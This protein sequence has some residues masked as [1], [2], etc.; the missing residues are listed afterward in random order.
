MPKKFEPNFKTADEDL[1]KEEVN[2]LNSNGFVGDL[3][4]DLKEPEKPDIQWA[5]E[6]IAKSYGIYMEFDRAATGREKDWYYM[7][8]VTIPGGGPLDSKAWNIRDSISNKYT[9]GPRSKPS[10][11]LTT[12]QNI[13][14]HWI[15]K[16]DMIPLVQEIASTGYSTLNGCGDNTRNV[17]ACPLSRYSN[18]FNANTWAFKAA[19]YFQLDDEP[20]IKI[21]AVDP[22]YLREEGKEPPKRFNY[23]NKLL[24][25]KFKIAFGAISRDQESGKFIQDNCAEALTNDLGIIPIYEN[26]KVENFQIYVGGGQGEKNGKLSLSTL[27]KPICI[28]GEDKL[29]EVM[30]SVVSVHKEWGDRQNRKWARVKYVIKAKGT[31]WYR[32][33]MEKVVGY[34]LEK[35]NTSLDIGQ[36]MLHHGWSK[37]ESNDKWAYGAFI[38]N[39]R[40][41]DEAENGKLSSMVKETLEEF[42]N[43]LVITPNQDLLFTNIDETAKDDFVKKLESYGYGKRN[44]KSYSKLRTLSGACVGR[45]TCRLTYT[46]SEKFEPSLIDALD[47]MGWSDMSESIGITGCERQCF[48]PSTKTIGLVGTGLNRYQLRLFGSEDGRTQGRP[49]YS[50]DKSVTYMR[51]IPR[52]EVPIVIDSL[53]KHYTEK[54]EGDEKMGTFHHR[55]G[56]AAILDF[57][58]NNEATKALM[59]KETKVKAYLSSE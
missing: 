48:R 24:N 1:C 45:D 49:L 38:E 9:T 3:E 17:M 39:G 25:R 2:K 34:K 27:A 6:Q 11:R 21:F 57:L 4:H 54:K 28:I 22:N 33:Q 42:K 35:P 8:R 5:S 16:E 41:S 32:E 46:D 53:F 50:E 29:L 44:G 23:G 37:Q 43:D 7:V 10:H 12:R 18:I 19:D 47:E 36:R 52:E 55:I 58:K 59:E 13:Q 14:Y 56:E 40:L 31:D 15:R 26:G 51:S 20:F 30:D